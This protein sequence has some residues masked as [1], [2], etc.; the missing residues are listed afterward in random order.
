MLSTKEKLKKYFT[1]E[2]AHAVIREKNYRCHPSLNQKH[3]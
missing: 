3:V 1:K 2:L